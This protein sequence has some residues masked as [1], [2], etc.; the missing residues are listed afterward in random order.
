MGVNLTIDH[1][2][3]RAKIGLWIS[4][5]DIPLSM[6]AVDRLDASSIEAILRDVVIDHAIY[7]SVAGRD[8]DIIDILKQRCGDVIEM[9]HRTT[10]PLK[11]VYSTPETLGP[12]RLAAAIGARYLMGDDMQDL[13]V[14]DLGTA[15]TYDVVSAGQCYLGGNIAP[16]ITMRLHALNSYTARLPIVPVNGETPVW[17]HDTTTALR[18][19]AVHGVV[20]EIEYYRQRL[21]DGCHVILTGGDAPTVMPLLP[22]YCQFK[23]DLVSLGL[24]VILDYNIKTKE[25]DGLITY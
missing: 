11:V 9:T 3:T 23:P 4:G 14:V 18:S 12:D 10:V 8:V 24:M 2:N 15:V 20:A 22:P 19:G 16:G 6:T 1:G 13:L 21:G 7:C 17:G 25:T 5:E